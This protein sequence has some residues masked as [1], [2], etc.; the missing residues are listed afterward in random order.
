YATAHYWYALYLNQLGRTDEAL[1][2]AQRAVELEPLS[3]VGTY[4]VGLVHY[5]ARDFDLARRYADKTLEISPQFLLGLRLRGMVDIPQGGYSEAIAVFGALHEAQPDSSLSAGLLAYA[6][7][8]AGDRAKAHAVLDPLIARSRDRFVSPAN[9][10]LG[11]V[12]TDEAD[13]A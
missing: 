7:G 9:I 12:G 6:Y 13:M 11:Y 5:F 1:V 8:R 4:A 2:Q 3:L 10:A